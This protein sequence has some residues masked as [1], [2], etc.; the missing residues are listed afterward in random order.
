MWTKQLDDVSL[1]IFLS[2]LISQQQTLCNRISIL[3]KKKKKKTYKNLGKFS[4]FSP[5]PAYSV[6]GGFVTCC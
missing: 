6:M 3:P 4:F 1:K 2:S 5:F